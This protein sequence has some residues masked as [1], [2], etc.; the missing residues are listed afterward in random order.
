MSIQPQ[1]TAPPVISIASDESYIDPGVGVD[2]TNV[3]QSPQSPTNPV[4]TLTDPDGNNVVLPD[5]PGVIQ[6][7]GTWFVTQPIRAGTVKPLPNGR[8]AFYTM[9]VTFTPS[10]TSNVISTDTT[11]ACPR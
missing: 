10:G 4:V 3:L 2:M 5:A 11:I 1:T 6:A 7:G 9:I 8:P